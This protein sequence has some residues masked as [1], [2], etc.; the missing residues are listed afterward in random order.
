MSKLDEIFTE[1]TKFDVEGQAY[2]DKVEAK[3]QI[4][5]LML[6]LVG[7]DTPQQVDNSRDTYENGLKRELRKK[8]ED[9]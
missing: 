1:V 8:I 7:E 4:K 5:S 2:V 3:A 9:L 6:E